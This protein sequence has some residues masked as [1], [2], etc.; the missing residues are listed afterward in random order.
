ME[1]YRK[2]KGEISLGIEDCCVAK[3]MEIN[4]QIS[5][6]Y[7]NALEQEVAQICYDFFPYK[8]FNFHDRFKY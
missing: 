2:D 7:F 8:L 4:I 3:G 5:T 6:I 1:S